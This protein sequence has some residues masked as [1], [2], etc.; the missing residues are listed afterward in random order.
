[1]KKMIRKTKEFSMFPE[2]PEIKK[3]YNY[4]QFKK[5]AWNRSLDK[6]NLAK[7]IEENRKDFKLHNFPIIVTEDMKVVDGQ[8]RLQVAK[9]LGSPVYYIVNG[10]DDSFKAVHS[11]NKAGKKHTMKDKL[12]MLNRAGDHGANLSYKAHYLY[13]EKFEVSTVAQ[14]L[15]NGSTGGGFKASIDTDGQIILKNY[16]NG[17]EVLDALFY[18]QMPNKFKPRTV[19]ALAFIFRH[20]GIHP[21]AILKRIE[22]NMVKWI[23]PK[24]TQETVRVMVNC[25]NYGLTMKNKISIK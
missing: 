4:D 1:M 5:I 6:S 15:T 13:Q 9:E 14:V 21:K 8:H 17:L 25:Y 3:S 22:A 19:F 10:K 11:V 23:D 18:S 20:S 2:S 12:E 24:S 7:L 16:D